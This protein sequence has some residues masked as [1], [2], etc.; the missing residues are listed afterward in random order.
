[1]TL[2]RV[3]ASRTPVVSGGARRA[4]SSAAMVN[5]KKF[6]DLSVHPSLVAFVEKD[7]L[8]GMRATAPVWRQPHPPT[9]VCLR[10]VRHVRRP[11]AVLGGA[12]RHRAWPLAK[13]RGAPRAA[14]RAAGARSARAPCTPHAALAELSLPR[15]PPLPLLYLAYPTLTTRAARPWLG[16]GLG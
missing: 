10:R 4:A 5:Y 8:P 6:G 9:N 12:G 1:M 14:R 7:V 3:L 16:L 13:E 2:L 15:L 11:C